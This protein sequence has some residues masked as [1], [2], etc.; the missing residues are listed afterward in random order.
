MRA[1]LI[2]TLLTYGSNRVVARGAE[3]RVLS[4]WGCLSD[5]SPSRT[6]E[7]KFVIASI[8]QRD[9]HAHCFMPFDNQ[10]LPGHPSSAE[11][12]KS[13]ILVHSVPIM[14]NTHFRVF[15]SRILPLKS[16]TPPPPDKSVYPEALLYSN[17]VLLRK[18]LF[19]AS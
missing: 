17:L 8:S 12:T 13:R 1:R 3:H 11:S 19:T 4:L 16:V 5:G 9:P 2:H 7:G 15:L 18:T 14:L 10:L 6:L